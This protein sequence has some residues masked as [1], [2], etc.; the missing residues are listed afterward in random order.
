MIP[1]SSPL[2]NSSVKE[3]ARP[4]MEVICPLDLV[5]HGSV[6][7]VRDAQTFAEILENP[8]GIPLAYGDS[9]AIRRR[10]RVQLAT[11]LG[12]ILAKHLGIPREEA[13]LHETLSHQRRSLDLFR[14]KIAADDKTPAPTVTF[15]SSELL[16]LLEMDD[17]ERNDI[18]E[19][20]VRL[21]SDF[22]GV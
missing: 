22:R 13:M 11:A 9:D 2:A 8:T 20:A 17:E 10:S 3:I 18:I 21:L 7:E 12:I 5:R 19:S 15:V 16:R 14:D 1:G 4:V 6:M